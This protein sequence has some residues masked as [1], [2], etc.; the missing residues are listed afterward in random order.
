MGGVTE[1]RRHLP[2]PPR[3]Y[4]EAAR[5]A[6]LFKGAL[7]LET[8]AAI[9]RLG[10]HLAG[11]HRINDWAFTIAAILSAPLTFIMWRR[12]QRRRDWYHDTRDWWLRLD[13]APPVAL[14]P[15][16]LDWI[17]RQEAKLYSVLTRWR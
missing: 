14:F 17:G 3:L 8:A 1:R 5:T 12:W 15:A 16:L 10:L 13:E 6:N 4:E 7:I 9:V 2:H 11:T